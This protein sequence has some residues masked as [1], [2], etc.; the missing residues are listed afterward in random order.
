MDLGSTLDLNLSHVQ[1]RRNSIRA[2]QARRASGSSAFADAVAAAALANKRGATTDPEASKDPE[3]AGSD[4]E[5]LMVSCVFCS[6]VQC[7]VFF[8]LW[9]SLSSVLGN[10]LWYGRICHRSRWRRAGRCRRGGEQRRRLI[11]S[12]IVVSDR[13]RVNSQLVCRRNFIRNK[14]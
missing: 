2:S 9:A 13:C 10:K 7:T 3:A 11:V 4:D 5:D 6:D 14:K 8:S 1:T 12:V